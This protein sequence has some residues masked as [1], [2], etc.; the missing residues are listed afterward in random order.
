M[1]EYMLRLSNEDLSQQK[2]ELRIGIHTGAIIAGVVGK[3]KFA[4]DVWGDSVNIASRVES[5]G[6]PNKINISGDTFELIKNFFQCTYRGKLPVKNRGEIDMYFV[7]GIHKELSI[8]E[9]GHTPNRLFM[10]KYN[11][12]TV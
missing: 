6:E 11:A 7:E 2:W 1:H 8:D 12:L 3:N 9:D 5:S 4:Y 10:E